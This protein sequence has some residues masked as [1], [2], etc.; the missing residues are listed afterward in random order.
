[1][2]MRK[3]I[4]LPKW[5]RFIIVILAKWNRFIIVIL[6]NISGMLFI[7]SSFSKFTK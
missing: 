6:A 3:T 2:E 7:T 5:N 1:M 4:E